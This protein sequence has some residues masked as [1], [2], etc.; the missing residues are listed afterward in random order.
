MTQYDRVF[1]F[2]RFWRLLQRPCYYYC[3]GPA[4][5]RANVVV[6]GGRPQLIAVARV[7]FRR[8]SRFCPYSCAPPINDTHAKTCSINIVHNN[9]HVIYR[10]KPVKK[11]TRVVISRSTNSLAVIHFFRP[12]FR[13][14]F[15]DTRKIKINKCLHCFVFEIPGCRRMNSI[16]LR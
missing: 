13:Y 2:S 11:I 6:V 1:G 16:T 14:D 15:R 5:P 12:P 8:P 4:L 3:I 7:F 9:I 10:V